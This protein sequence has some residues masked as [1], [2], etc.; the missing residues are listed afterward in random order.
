MSGNR[1]SVRTLDLGKEFVEIAAQLD[2]IVREA[3]V[4]AHDNMEKRP[5]RGVRDSPSPFAS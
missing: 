3:F 5:A 4:P 1:I 2:G